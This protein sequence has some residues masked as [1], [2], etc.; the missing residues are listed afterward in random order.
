M[1]LFPTNVIAS[2]PQQSKDFIVKDFIETLSDSAIPAARKSGITG[3]AQNQ[4][5][6]KPL[7]RSFEHALSRLNGLSEDLAAR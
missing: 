3:T 5:D 1:C 4:F 7:I 2:D 6:P